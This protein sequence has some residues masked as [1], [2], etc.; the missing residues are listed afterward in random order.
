MHRT[1]HPDRRKLSV[2]MVARMLGVAEHKILYW[3]H[4]GELKATNLA[5]TVHGRPR[6]AIDRDDIAD[7]E[8]AR[9]VVPD[10]SVSDTRKLR[11]RRPGTVKDFF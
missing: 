9:Q 5:R 10:A 7:F 11:R 1:P 8:R 2:P 4:S 6:Y 3:I